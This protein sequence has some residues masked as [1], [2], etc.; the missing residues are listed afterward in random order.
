[1]STCPTC[2]VATRL[3]RA[4]HQTLCL[5]CTEAEIGVTYTVLH[6]RVIALTGKKTRR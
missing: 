3:S 2:G 1:M 4:G 5:P 6:D